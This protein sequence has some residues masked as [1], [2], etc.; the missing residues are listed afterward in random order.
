MRRTTIFSAV[1]VALISFTLVAEPVH[2]QNANPQSPSSGGS[3]PPVAPPAYMPPAHSGP[4]AVRPATIQQDVEVPAIL[5]GA[6]AQAGG[7]KSPLPQ[8]TLPDRPSS[9][10]AAFRPATGG[11]FNGNPSSAGK[12]PL[13]S[14]TQDQ[15]RLNPNDHGAFVQPAGPPP[16]RLAE[17]PNWLR[18]QEGFGS[19]EPPTQTHRQDYQETENVAMT[20]HP[21]QPVSATLRDTDE[22]TSSLA[23]PGNQLIE[24]NGPRLRVSWQSPEKIS[25]NKS[26]RF[27]VVVENLENRRAENIVVG[28]DLPEWIEINNSQ[29]TTGSRETSDGQGKPRIIWE[30]PIVES[31]STEKMMIDVTPKDARSFDLNV[32]WTFK[33]IRGKATVQ[34]TQPQLMVQ[35]TGPAEVQFG[36]KALYHVTVSNPG[37]GTAEN[38]AVMLPEVLGGERAVLGNIE[39][40]QQRQFEVEL[41]ARTA[42]PL[43][44]V[45]TVTADTELS[46]SVTREIMVRRAA[47]EVQV[48]G[49]PMKF[50]GNNAVYHV[51]VANRGDAVARDVI[52]AVAMPGGV[53]YVAGIEGAETIDG[54]IRWNVGMLSPGNHR[55]YQIECMIASAGEIHFE[56]AARG[57]GDLAA[58]DKIITRV[59]A[60]ADLVLTVEDPQGPLPVGQS[61]AYEVTILNRGTKSAK[62]VD[63][64]MHFSEGIEPL[65][66]E[67]LTHEMA[68]GQITF[69]P[70]AQIDPGQEISLKVI[71]SATKAGSHRFRAQLLCEESDAHE[72]AEGTTKFFGEA[73]TETRNATAPPNQTDFIR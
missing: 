48:E 57:Y 15:S 7:Q 55:T 59:D 36:E 54:G 33:P 64:V 49:P 21:V 18:S 23:A 52:A 10:A 47:L 62:G 17:A 3:Q 16:D 25:L 20:Q 42:G 53:Q 44:L 22:T 40:Q 66:A 28:I 46:E 4:G 32:E 9:P 72:V 5:S 8:A 68:A 63:V 35:M 1:A 38:V 34:V 6:D 29:P 65:D 71:A 11:A 67:G 13:T 2:S 31:S 12:A 14:P 50:A 61:I 70:I 58:T 69:S 26:S 30:I 19:S 51:T 43:D 41:I 45:T 24:T 39:P 73:T 37:T 60:V 27:E 56:A